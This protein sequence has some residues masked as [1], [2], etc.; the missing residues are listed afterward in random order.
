MM[1]V[2]VWSEPVVLAL[3][4][5][6]TSLTITVGKMNFGSQL[7]TSC[8]SRAIYSKRKPTRAGK[9][10]TFWQQPITSLRRVNVWRAAQTRKRIPEAQH[11]MFDR[12]SNRGTRIR[13]S[14]TASCP[15]QICSPT[16]SLIF[17]FL[18]E[19]K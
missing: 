17:C 16:M 10:Y 15:L 8:A 7:F 5:I 18:P 14:F 3:I 2:L 12:A 19:S 6:C 1:V 11:I 4:M 13:P 9:A